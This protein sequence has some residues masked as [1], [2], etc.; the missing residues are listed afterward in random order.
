MDQIF[1]LVEVY[2]THG[3]ASD[4]YAVVAVLDSH[5]EAEAAVQKLQQSGID[6]KKCSI[7]GRER[8]EGEQVAAYYLAGD[9]ITSWGKSGA[10]WGGIWGLVSGAGIFLIPGIGPVLVGGTF[11]T[12]LIGALQGAV[13][14]GG[15]SAL[16]AGFYNIGVPLES[17][18]GYESAVKGDR[19]VVIVHS[20]APEVNR[21]KEILETLPDP[22]KSYV[23]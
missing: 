3:E 17:I 23:A 13:V 12:A 5:I 18:V 2:K 14:V 6:L 9:R 22:Q 11:V 4:T 8:S 10:F 1:R 15:L 21:A 7:V 16:G 20:T 19:F